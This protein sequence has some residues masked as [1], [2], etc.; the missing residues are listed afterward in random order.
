MLLINVLQHL[1]VEHFAVVISEK[2]LEVFQTC[3]SSWGVLGE[4]AKAG[5][6]LYSWTSLVDA[7]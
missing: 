4:D 1:P 7:S 3:S 5:A 6:G 2:N